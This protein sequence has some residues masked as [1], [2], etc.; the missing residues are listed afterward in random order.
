M[1]QRTIPGHA[2]MVYVAADVVRAPRMHACTSSPRTAAEHR[3]RQGSR[4]AARPCTQRERD[5]VRQHVT[6]Q[7]VL[8]EES[9]Q[10]LQTHRVLPY[11]SGGTM[12]D[13]R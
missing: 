13:V 9:L 8:P 2:G 4:S 3:G 11:S 7:D 1:R 10:D 5:A 6:R 12:H